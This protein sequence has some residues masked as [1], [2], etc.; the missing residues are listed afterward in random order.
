L[1][2]LGFTVV[3]SPKTSNLDYRADFATR[4]AGLGIERVRALVQSPLV[5]LSAG[6][7]FPQDPARDEI[8]VSSSDLG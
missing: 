3:V 4:L 1:E 7:R 6:R 5:N 2:Q 8:E